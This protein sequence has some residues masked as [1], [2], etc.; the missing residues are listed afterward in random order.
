MEKF[1]FLVFFCAFQE[2][3]QLVD[4]CI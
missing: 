1:G 4:M 2:E 3:I